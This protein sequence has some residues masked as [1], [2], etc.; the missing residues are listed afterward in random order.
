VTLPGAARQLVKLFP[1]AFVPSRHAVVF[2]CSSTYFLPDWM[3]GRTLGFTVFSPPRSCMPWLPERLTY[4][5]PCLPRDIS[6]S[7][8]SNPLRGYLFRALAPLEVPLFRCRFAL[9]C[10]KGLA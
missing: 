4:T 2:Y 3:Q 7:D 1:I 6:C 9:I 10:G 8:V 5:P